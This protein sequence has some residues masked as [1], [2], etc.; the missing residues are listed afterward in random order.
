MGKLNASALNSSDRTGQNYR[1]RLFSIL[2]LTCLLTS[3][4]AYKQRNVD[5]IRKFIGANEV[6]IFPFRLSNKSMSVK[7]SLKRIVLIIF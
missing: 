6:S 1:I 3:I 2:S 4:I 5:Y 7:K